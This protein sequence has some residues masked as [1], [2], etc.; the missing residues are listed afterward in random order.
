MQ[1]LK[2]IVTLLEDMRP[3]LERCNKSEKFTIF[4]QADKLPGYCLEDAMTWLTELHNG[5]YKECQ[6]IRLMQKEEFWK[7]AEAWGECQEHREVVLYNERLDIF[8]RA[9]RGKPL[10]FKHKDCIA[11]MAENDRKKPKNKAKAKKNED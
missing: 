8:K 6:R 7:R 10:I 4:A 9:L 1:T 11:A 5:P 2:S 3:T